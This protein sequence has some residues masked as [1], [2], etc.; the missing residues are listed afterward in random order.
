V[1]AAWRGARRQG[2]GPLKASAFVAPGASASDVAAMSW[3]RGMLF[4]RAVDRR[5]ARSPLARVN[6]AVRGGN[7]FI[8]S[9]HSSSLR[10]IIS[11]RLRAIA[12]CRLEIIAPGVWLYFRFALFLRLVRGDAARTWHHHLLR[13]LPAPSDKIRP[14]RR[15]RPTGTA[16]SYDR[17]IQAHRD[18]K[19]I[20]SP[21]RAFRQLIS[22]L[23][24][25]TALCHSV[26]WRLAR[27]RR[28]ARIWRRN[29][30]P[31]RPARPH[32]FQCPLE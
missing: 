29:P 20:A 30:A 8:V 23:F 15:A 17:T 12:G 31:R 28:L 5:R 6:G 18:P 26:Q 1:S 22:W 25:S 2:R 13:T 21:D 14:G 4:S 16:I 11:L 32:G 27:P 3:R 9:F 7:Y 10:D 24:C 19:T